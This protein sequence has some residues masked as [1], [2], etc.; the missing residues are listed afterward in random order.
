M[1]LPV[2][3]IISCPLCYLK[4]KELVVAK[5]LASWIWAVEMDT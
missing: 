3:I 4:L 2:L 1:L 5:Q